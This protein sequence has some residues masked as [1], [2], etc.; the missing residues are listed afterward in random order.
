MKVSFKKTVIWVIAVAVVALV[1]IQPATQRGKYVY[2]IDTTSN[3]C[4]F[5]ENPEQS[6]EAGRSS[7]TITVP[8]QTPTPCY[9]VQGDVSFYGSDIVVNLKTVKKG[10]TCAECIGVVAAKVTISNLDRGTYSVQINAPDR[11]LQISTVKVGE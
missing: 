10:E 2:Q 3:K 11:A 6:I 9:E 4:T 8:I 1:L 7:M 5:D